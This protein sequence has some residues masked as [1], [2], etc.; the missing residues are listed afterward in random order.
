MV[1]AAR[2][3]RA[4]LDVPS[5]CPLFWERGTYVVTDEDAESWGALAARVTRHDDP[6]CAGLSAAQAT[7][8]DLA[9]MGPTRELVQCRDC[10]TAGEREFGRGYVTLFY[11]ARWAAEA[12]AKL[13]A[14]LTLVRRWAACADTWPKHWSALT[15]AAAALADVVHATSVHPAMRPWLPEP[16][17][18]LLRE[19][20]DAI[21]DW[22]LPPGADSERLEATAAWAAEQATILERE[23]K[24][25]VTRWHVAAA[26]PGPFDFHGLDSAPQMVAVDVGDTGEGTSFFVCAT[27]AV[28][29]SSDSTLLLR[30]PTGVVKRI[31]N[32]EAVPLPTQA[33]EGA[34]DRTQ[35][36]KSTGGASCVYAAVTLAALEGAR[37]D[38]TL[39]QACDLAAAAMSQTGTP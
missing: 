36:P 30:L 28:L 3:V 23:L 8:V 4:L 17:V 2:G 35:G 24:D 26:T 25:L 1:L 20:I 22:G 16:G 13:T 9:T 15:D 14:H 12:A 34:Q 7:V 29:A 32:A 37:G 19:H 27:A 6:S 39:A 5:A 31:C 18:S 21:A 11:A 38:V 33:E 10:F